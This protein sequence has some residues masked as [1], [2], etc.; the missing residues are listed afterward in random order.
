MDS[1]LNQLHEGNNPEQAFLLLAVLALIIL[2]GVALF[3]ALIQ[4]GGLYNILQ[5]R[6]GGDTWQLAVTRWWT[7]IYDAQVGLKPLETEQELLLAHDYDGIT[8][9]DNHLPPWWKNLF[10]ATILFG[11]VYMVMYHITGS[12]Q[13]Q[14]AEY[15]TELSVAATKKAE[16]E[17]TQTNSINETSA[18]F[19]TDASTINDGKGI[20]TANCVACHGPAAGGGVGPNLTDSYWLH[21]NTINDVFKTIKYGVAGK[22]MTA[23]QATLNPKQI[24]SVASYVLSLNGS[25]PANAKEPQGKLLANTAQAKQATAAK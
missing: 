20:Y 23:W 7:S 21:G 1:I 5:K 12:W 14:I 22:G 2:I 6:N 11:G 19:L 16:W 25:N 15:E 10:Y 8:E 18:K 13:L 24:Q 4:I 9:L 17:K 3:I